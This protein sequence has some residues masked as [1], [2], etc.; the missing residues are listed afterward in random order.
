MGWS[1]PPIPWSELERELSDRRRPGAA[2]RRRRRRQPGLVAQT[3]ALRARA[4]V[5]APPG[6]R[7]ALRRAARALQLQLPRRRQRARGARRGGGPARASHA[8]AL[9]DHD[10][11]YGIV[12]MAEAAESYPTSRPSSAP[13]CRSASSA[14]QN[15]VADP[16]GSHLLVLARREEGYHRLAGA[17]TARAAGRAARRASPSTTSSELADRGG[18]RTGWSSPDAARARCGR[19]CAAARPGSR[20]R[21]NSTGWSPSSAHDN[22]V[23]ELF[24]HGHPARQQPQRRPRRARRATPASRWSPRATCTTRPR[25]STSWPRRS[26]RCGPGAASTRWTAGCRPP[27]AR[28]CAAAPRWRARFARYPGAV[29]RTVTIADELAFPL[30]RRHARGCRSRRCPT[31]TRR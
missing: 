17:I 4:A 18:R 29:E 28:T 8:L 13:S 1:N 21:A 6:P 16:E 15:G 14:P 25:P 26:P 19:P 27:T 7:R 31:G 12:R 20:G 24:D 22:V 10:G 23:V 5:P 30:R 9:T 11:L 3:A 2:G